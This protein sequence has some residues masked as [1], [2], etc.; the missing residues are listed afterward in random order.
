MG[1]LDMIFGKKNNSN[2]QTQRVS[3]GCVTTTK[4]DISAGNYDSVKKEFIAFDTETTG[5]SCDNDRIVELGAVLFR[6]GK[7][8]S[9]FGTLVNPGI[10]IPPQATAVNHITNQM[11]RTAPDEI[12]AYGEFCKFFEK[13]LSGEVVVCAHNASFDMKFISK[14]LERLGYSGNINYIDTLTLSRKMLKELPNHK[15]PTV[16]KH[17]GHINTA[18][19]RAASDAE[20][21]GLILVSLLQLKENEIEAEKRDFEKKIPTEAEQ[22]YC[23][24]IQRL[25]V[26]AGA[27]SDWLK[28]YRNSASYVD[29]AYLYELF[30]FKMAKKGNYIIVEKTELPRELGLATEECTATEGG[31]SVVR[32]FFSEPSDLDV[33]LPFMMK[34]Y[35]ALAPQAIDYIRGHRGEVE[36]SYGNWFSIADAE[37]E[38]YIS[39]GVTR[40]EA[41]QEELRMAE[42][43]KRL[44]EEEKRLKK[45]SAKKKK[46]VTSCGSESRGNRSGSRAILQMDDEMH[47]INRFESLQAAINQTG[48]NSKSIRDAAK[49]VQKHAGGFVWR[50]ADEFEEETTE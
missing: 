50:Y 10:S 28:F 19:H 3:R 41:M 42:E 4:I 49:G 23:A 43:Q 46:D 22:E 11:L 14:T 34:Q 24:Y 20:V 16:A 7:K 17:F 47:I 33:L 40:R 9:E 48:I 6:D 8:V 18:E 27:K 39:A 5:L 31:A 29:V 35:N 21:C 12:R 26:N 36:A 25:M 44:L 45:E 13:A 15:Q 30:K 2:V 38:N 37:V 32:V 1:I